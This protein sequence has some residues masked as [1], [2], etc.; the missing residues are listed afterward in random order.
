METRANSTQ[1]V[2]TNLIDLGM[3]SLTRGSGV[4]LH[5]QL[6][7]GLREAILNGQLPVGVRL[8]PTR[9]LAKQLAVSRNTVVNAFEQLMAEGYLVTRIGAGTFVSEALP[10]RW[11]SV[12]VP[13]QTGQVAVG[14][15]ANLSKRGHKIAAI[16]IGSR[17]NVR[18]FLPGMPDVRHFPFSVWEKLLRQQRHTM[19]ALGY[20]DPQ[21]ASALREALATHLQL[22]RGL[23]CS[24]DQIIITSGTQHSLDVATRLLSDAGDT[25]WMENPGYSRAVAAFQCN[26]LEIIPVPVTS[27]GFDVEAAQRSSSIARLAYVTPSHQYPLGVTMSA[28]RRLELLAWAAEN[29]GWILE[30]DYD[31]EFRFGGHPLPCLQGMDGAGRVIYIGT[32]SKV[33]FPALRLGYVVVPRGLIVAFRS[34]IAHTSRT[35]NWVTQLAMADFLREG[36]YARHVRRMRLLYAE[37]Q[38]VLLAEIAD[39]QLP[40]A[41]DATPAGLH[42]LAWLPVDVDDVAISAELAAHNIAAPPLSYYSLTPLQRG[43]LVLGFGGFDVTEIR[44]AITRMGSLLINSKLLEI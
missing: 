24:A 18:P 5:R 16:P 8:P 9:T 40:L 44:H 11:L 14:S 20:N 7:E 42:V 43:G 19:A 25:V 10:E 30:D 21:G 17:E 1:S 41:I 31:S 37:R 33:L 27:N 34:A 12:E 3:I 26:E 35:P 23:R 39:Q 36:H 4:S 32:F 6:F 13:R 29:D 38:R 2:G 15:H 28:A 22:A